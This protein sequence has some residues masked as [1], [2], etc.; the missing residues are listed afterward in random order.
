MTRMT[1][2]PQGIV[3]VLQTPFRADGD[4]DYE[5]LA[6]LIEDAIE[7]GA[8]GF[9]S[10]A[11]ASEVHSLTPEERASLLAFV[12]S[13]THGRVPVIA[14]C[15]NADA[16]TCAGLASAAEVAG[17]SAVLIAIPDALRE[18]EDELAAFFRRAMAH[19]R[20]PLIIQDLDWSGRGL[21]L[22]GLARLREE[23]PQ[24]AGA[25][26][27]SVPAGPKYTAVRS[28]C[29]HGFHI[30][31]GW[32]AQQFI[33]ALDRGVDALIPEASMTRVYNAIRRL[34]E[35][36]RREE[37]ITL[38]RQFLPVVAFTNQEI[39]LSIAFFKR[40][41][42]RR[43]IFSTP[44]MRPPAFVW[45]DYSLHIADELIELCLELISRCPTPASRRP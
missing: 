32:A 11:V 12:L 26:I 27:E 40:L 24:L 22:E 37:A 33:E 39:G 36:G 4:I 15:S 42:V 30:S 1:R 19:C 9:L 20:L 3:P 35:H 10:P 18:A 31:G 23:I 7:G 8:A 41:L 16:T 2:P 5:S 25:K 17:A 34:H 45:D 44:L 29:G 14:G 6:R 13:H 21:S 28:L 38:F 43:G